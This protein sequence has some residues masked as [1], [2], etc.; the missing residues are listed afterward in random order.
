MEERVE[1][2]EV[3][4]I[5]GEFKEEEAKDPL[6][7]VREEKFQDA[8]ADM[9]KDQ[10]SAI[11]EVLKEEPWSGKILSADGK[12]LVINAGKD[13]G[14][15][16]GSLFEVFG[17]GESIQSVNGRSY[18]LLGPKMGEIKAVRVMDDHASAVPWK[19]AGFKAGQTI[20]AKN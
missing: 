20:R 4:R 8:M 14:L 13:V 9:V 17:K 5:Q 7:F 15:I 3:L 2:L 19:G 11:M 12:N 18:H 1:D 6:S 16:T 10:A